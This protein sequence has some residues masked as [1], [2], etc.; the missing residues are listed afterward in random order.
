MP[1]HCVCAGPLTAGRAAP[2]KTLRYSLGY[3]PLDVQVPN[4][5]T[6]CTPEPQHRWRSI[7]SNT[8]KK[9]GVI[10][11]LN[12]NSVIKRLNSKMKE[13]GNNFTPCPSKVF[14]TGVHA[15]AAYQSKAHQQ[16]PEAREIP[17]A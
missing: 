10:K 9:N 5:G 12:S 7:A 16:H 8:Q 14:F 1:P 17:V 3:H 11:R 13:M 4:A 6:G 15:T 2:T